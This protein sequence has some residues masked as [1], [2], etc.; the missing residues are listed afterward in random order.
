MAFQRREL[1]RWSAT[2]SIGSAYVDLSVILELDLLD[3]LLLEQVDLLDHVVLELGELLLAVE[4]DLGFIIGFVVG[5][6]GDVF[7]RRDGA[8]GGLLLPVEDLL[9]VAHGDMAV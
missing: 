3:L 9:L 4:G 5:A 8:G 7:C 1:S 2:S 6:F